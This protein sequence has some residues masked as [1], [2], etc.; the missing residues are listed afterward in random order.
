MIDEKRGSETVGGRKKSELRSD[1]RKSLKRPLCPFVVELFAG[2]RVHAYQ[3]DCGCGVRTRCGRVLKRLSPHVQTAHR[4]SVRC[5]VEKSSTLRVAVLF[6]GD[7][8]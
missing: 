6:N 5:A 8:H 7:V 3:R 1:F 2:K 4:R